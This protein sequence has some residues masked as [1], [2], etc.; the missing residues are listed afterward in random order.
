MAKIL[1]VDDNPDIVELIA[2]RLEVN[3]YDVLTAASGEEALTS[4]Q[5]DQPDLILLD[6]AMPGIDG[7]ETGRRLK[8][9]D[10]TKNI[11]IIMVTAKGEQ[12]D[13]LKA[14]NEVKAVGY[15]V[16]PFRPDKLLEKVEE[17]LAKKK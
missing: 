14:V 4:A 12:T 15:I 16:K 17:A 11:P 10:A 7:F 6:V 2:S 3:N 8:A 5:K 13:L 9:D 1:I